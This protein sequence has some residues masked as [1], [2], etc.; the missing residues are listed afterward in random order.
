MDEDTEIQLRKKL[1]S[2]R[3]EHRDLDDVIKRLSE[4]RV[5]DQLQLQRLKK[6]KLQLKDFI[7]IIEDQLIPDLD[8]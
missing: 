2:L 7:A 5:I 3:L 1:E 4:D 6:R 8:A